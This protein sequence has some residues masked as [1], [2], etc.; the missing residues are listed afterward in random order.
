MSIIELVKYESRETAAV[1]RAL[2]AKAT[3]GE[4]RGLALCYR[5]DEGAEENVFTG[6]YKAR[7]ESAVAAIHRMSWQM[8]QEYDSIYGPP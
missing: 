6:V 4:L 2:L 5:T 3:K 8:T 7:P 1:L